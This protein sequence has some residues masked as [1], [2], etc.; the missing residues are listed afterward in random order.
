MNYYKVNKIKLQSFTYNLHHYVQ[1]K[2]E[3]KSTNTYYMFKYKLKIRL[4][5]PPPHLFTDL[6]KN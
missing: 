5:L 2:L 6:K 1:S 4:L 3:S